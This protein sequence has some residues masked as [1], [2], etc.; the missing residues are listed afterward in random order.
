MPPRN[1]AG[2]DAIA[3]PEEK[4]VLFDYMERKGFMNKQS[5]S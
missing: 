4:Q 1:T 2:I 5:L 3:S